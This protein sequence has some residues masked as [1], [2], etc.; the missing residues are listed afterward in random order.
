[1]FF[2]KALFQRFIN[3]LLACILVLII[4]ITAM[5]QGGFNLVLYPP[6]LTQFPKITLYLDA[7]DAQ[8]Q[9]IPSLDLKSFKVFEDGF[10]STLNE[11]QLIEPGL[12]TIVALNLGPTLS[13]RANTT[14]PTRYEETVYAVAAWLTNLKSAAPNQYSLTSNEGALADSVQDNGMFIYRLQNYKPNL[15]NFQPDLSSLSQALEIAARPKLN[16]QGK[17]V[18][19]LITPLPLDQSMSTLPAMQA[20]AQEL[21][22]PVNV[23]LVAPETAVNSPAAVQLSALAASTGGKFLFYPENLTQPNVEDYVRRLRNTY[24]L[25][26]TSS[27]SKS[28][29]HTVR[30]EGKYGNETAV[31]SDVQFG[32][33]LNLPT[34]VL[35][36]LPDVIK[37]T[38]VSSGGKKNLQPGFITLQANFLFPDGYTRQLKAA[39]LYVDGVLVAENQQEPFGVFAWPLTNYQFSGEHLLS[40]EV[41]DI[42]GFRSISP[43]VSVSVTVES[44]YPSWLTL[45]M[46]F[47]SA[48]GW[49]PV[50]IIA[51]G[52]TVIFSLRLRKRRMAAMENTDGYFEEG[53]LDPLTQPVPG[54][55]SS[56]FEPDREMNPENPL[57]L[58]AEEMPP[59]LVWAG[60]LPSP[61]KDGMIC[62]DRVEIIIG[63]DPNQCS[64]PVQAKGVSP[65]HAC[66][67]RQE[68][69]AVSIADLGSEEGTWVNFAPIS[70]RGMILNDGDLV[71]IGSLTF[72]YQIGRYK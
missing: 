25:R 39:R 38:Y 15:F 20:R 9:F 40:V 11:T 8:G 35:V 64:F 66:L 45:L 28:G 1:M 32:I 23:W 27:L 62:V 21:R 44:L 34:A 4:P 7:F 46:K 53:N 49:I 48:G 59:C 5:A 26:Y 57:A 67:V 17:E 29:A 69:G 3:A 51:L 55:G 30:V 10:E 56:L 68:S 42:L 31:T 19:L 16:S 60:E 18:V 61:V 52:S 24:R 33:S 14:V 71:Q 58:G 43:Q 6:D 41:E 22:V 36:G 47:L 70:G 50:A 12:H 54:L 37:R 72:R 65:Q 63:S 13:N 2:R